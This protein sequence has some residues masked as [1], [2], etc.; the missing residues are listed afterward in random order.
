M[1]E[2]LRTLTHQRGAVKGKLTRV[3]SAIQHSDD[4]PNTNIRN[5]HYLR[6]HQKTVDQAYSEYNDFQNLIYALPL[7]E[8]RRAEQVAKYIEF[9]T[10]YNDLSIRLSMLTEEATKEADTKKE[11]VAMTPASMTFGS[12]LPFLSPL[13]APLPTFDGSY[14]RW[15]SFK[16][17]FNTI[18]DRYTHEEPAIKLYHLRNSLVGPVAG[19]IDQDIVNNNDYDAAWRFLTERFEDKRLIIDKHIECLFNLPNIVKDNS[20]N[21]RKLLDV[22]NKNIEALKNLNLQLEGLGE[23]MVVNMISS[24]MDKATRVAWETRQKPGILPSYTATMTFLQE[25]CRIIEKIETSNKV[26]SVKPKAVAK[27][28]TLVNINEQKNETKHELKCAVCKNNHELWKCENFK[29]MNVSDKYNMLKKSGCCFNCLQK[30]HR[31]NGCTSTHNC[32]ECGKRHHTSLHISEGSSSKSADSI[33]AT[34]CTTSDDAHPPRKESNSCNLV[35]ASRSG[36]ATTLCASVGSPVKQTLL[37][38]AVVQIRGSNSAVYPCRILLDSASQV[39]FV[40]ERFVNLVAPKK[41]PVDY[42]VS[43]LNGTNTRLRHRVHMTIESCIGDFSVDLEFLVAPRITGDI[44]QRSFSASEWSIPTD[45]KL[46]DPEFHTRG[47]IDML[48]GAEIFWDV[49]KGDQIKLGSNLPVLTN[50]EF[51]WVAGGIISTDVPVIAKSFCQ[52]ADEDL[53]ELLRSF[54]K[55]EAC[56]EIQYSN[57]AAD[58][59]CL[60][61][62]RDTHQRDQEGRYYVRHPFNDMINELGESRTM[63]TR[64]FLSLERRLDRE[65]EIKQQYACFM[66][67]YE[68]LGHMR[69]ITVDDSEASNTVYYIPHHCVVKPTSTST[70]LRVV[71]DGSAPSSSGVAINDAL[72]TGPNVQ[73]DLF[74]IL[75]NYRSYRY[76]FTVNAVKMFR[77]VGVLPPDTAYQRIV[78]RYDRNEPLTVYE[79]STVTYGLASS[80]FQATMALRQTSEDHQ[81]EFPQASKVIKKSAYMDDVIAGAHSIQ[82]ACALQQEV[83]GLLAKG[84]FETHKWCANHSEILQH[85]DKESCGT[86]FNVGDINSNIIKTLGV[87][88]NPL[89]DWFSFSVEPGNPEATTKRKILSEVAKIYD[90]LGIVGPIVTAA[91]LI[92]REVSVLAVDWD[93]PVPHNIVLKWQY[94]RDELICLNELRVPRWIS[95]ADAM[96]VQL[97]GFSDASDVA[98]G[99]CLYSRVIHQNGSVTMHL[100]CSKSRI[101]PKKSGKCKPITTPRAELL[102]AVLLSKLVE[103]AI[104][105]IDIDFESVNLWTDSQIVYCWIR[106]P[107]EVLQLYVSNRVTEIQRITGAYKWRYVPSQ[108]NPAD[109]ISRGEFPR[110]LLANTMWWDGPP[111]LKVTTIE[112]VHPAPLADENLPEMKAGVSLAVTSPVKRLLIFDRANDYDRILRAMAYLIR[113]AK[114]FTSRK[115]MIV[116]GP[117]TVPELRAALA[118]T[119]RCV[120]MEMFHHEL[121]V[122]TEG[123][124]TK[125]RLCGLKPFIDSQDGIMRVGGRIKNAL[126]PYDSRHQMLLPAGHPFSVA[127]VKNLHRSNLHI[128]QKGLLAMVRQRFWPLRV[129]S[130]IRKIIG[131][132]ITCFR[133]NPLKTSQLMGDLPSYRVQPAPAFAYTGVDY[134]G[135]FLIKSFTA[136]RRPLVTKA[137]VCLFV[138]MVTRAIHVELV[139]DLTT[140]AFLAA[141]RRFTSRRG[142]PCKMYSDNATNFVGAQNELEELARLFND[143]QQSK[144]I[145]DYCTNQGIEWSFI[146]PRSPHFG[147]IWEAGVKQVKHHLTRIVG[148]CKLSYE[149]L[150]TTLTQIEAV[151]NSRPLAPCSDDPCDLSAITPAHFL[152]GREMQAVPEPSYLDLKQ[153]TLSRWQLVQTIFQ[154]FWRRWTA[155]YLPELQNRSKWTKTINITKGSLVLVIDQNVPPFQWPLGRVKELHP[156]T[157]CAPKRELLPVGRNF[158]AIANRPEADRSVITSVRGGSRDLHVDRIHTPAHHQ[159]RHGIVTAIVSACETPNRHLPPSSKGILKEKELQQQPQE[160]QPQQWELHNYFVWP[161]PR[162]ETSVRSRQS[163]FESPG[164]LLIDHNTFQFNCRSKVPARRLL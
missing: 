131:S 77:Q 107:P 87:V 102:G 10:M 55:L 120:Q 98:Y 24:R 154:H 53:S 71:F 63:A 30:G 54:Y 110:K 146:P 72:L 19:I 22:C 57:K 23:Q 137:Y 162:L 86:N 134:A 74:C 35:E 164:F 25:Q 61:H 150:Y 97:H 108:Q 149:E 117:L 156:A 125:H 153:S 28:H 47:R 100:I 104:A 138:C 158:L 96:S 111:M 56:D 32:R 95:T 29:K 121:R 82:D 50:T 76:V 151:L 160:Q 144:K 88:W 7:S 31:T 41:E 51:G 155:E 3:K 49:V 69:A 93:D 68:D 2:Q 43:G 11:I 15:F 101:L 126:I 13:Q 8:E 112:E 129:K 12:T 163:R 139:S 132:C 14:E 78:Y 159:N 84:C 62:F 37:S 17:M 81:H 119:V 9:E 27:A 21:L 123:R 42:T 106:K 145:T 16:S 114:Y 1:E 65:P 75:L 46:A 103:K 147:G 122:I 157:N 94:F 140:D 60:E 18:M 39:H 40:T 36:T 143:Q 130:T 58:D 133:A 142:L 89:D 4:A 99:A 5:L 148:G 83:S 73:N 161:W 20:V 66:H 52:I 90:L 113:F 128:G 141:L 136:G 48:V 44:P 85:V 64:R 34:Q 67:E 118:V 59:R 79:L 6:L 152:I 92:L 124:Q 127:V 115:K 80:P 38:T 26:E 109:I 70:K 105:A 135:P 116:R 91:K 45:I 33:A